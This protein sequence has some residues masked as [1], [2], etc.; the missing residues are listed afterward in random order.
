MVHVSHIKELAVG[1]YGV[2]ANNVLHLVDE[3]N[4]IT[5]IID[6]NFI[7]I[8]YDSLLGMVITLD[9]QPVDELLFKNE[10][11]LKTLKITGV[12]Y[13][14]NKVPSYM[15]K[16]KLICQYVECFKTYDNGVLNGIFKNAYSE[17][18]YRNGKKTGVWKYFDYYKSKFILGPGQYLRETVKIVTYQNGI[19]NGDCELNNYNK[20]NYA[21][22]KYLNGKK[23]GVWI[24][25]IDG[26]NYN[27]YVTYDKGI[28]QSVLEIK[29]DGKP[30]KDNI[31]EDQV[32]YDKSKPSVKYY[33]KVYRIASN[34]NNVIDHEFTKK[35]GKVICQEYTYEELI[36]NKI[37]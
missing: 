1:K 31:K 27:R 28:P 10:N 20:N 23:Q 36:N 5:D 34:V 17:G 29:R 37:E 26:N 19:W 4:I 16:G 9:K 30:W 11:M 3:N 13:G 12:I 32:P 22:G 15:E 24:Y 2:Y 35:D 7:N 33:P 18:Y 6:E 25:D 14:E 21:K 8:K